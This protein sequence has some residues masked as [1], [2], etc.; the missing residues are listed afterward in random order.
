MESRTLSTE[1]EQLGDTSVHAADSTTSEKALNN[2]K[3]KNQ[4]KRK[5]PEAVKT[6]TSETVAT[7]C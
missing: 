5:I 7:A 2:T 3:T 4:E 6:D 1:T